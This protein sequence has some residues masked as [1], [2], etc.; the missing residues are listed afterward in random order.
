MLNLFKNNDS[1]KAWLLVGLG[2]PGDKYAGN[3]HNVGFMVIDAIAKEYI[4]PSFRSK[5]HGEVSESHIGGTKVVILK[6]MTMMNESGVSVGTAANFFKIPPERVIVFHDE[7]DLDAGKVRVKNGGGN[8][9]HNGLKSIQSHLKTP[10]FIRVRI[11]IGHPGNKNKVHSYVLKDFA[12][13]ERKWL[14]PLLDEIASL[15]DVLIKDGKDKFMTIIAQ[16]TNQG[17]K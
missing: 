12:K 10:D 14:E 4:F 7:L 2:N 11:G 5:F 16:N 13:A 9:G 6:P 3:R 15:V 8:A 1:S 17:K